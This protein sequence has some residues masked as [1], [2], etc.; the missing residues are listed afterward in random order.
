MTP[1][2]INFCKVA[3]LITLVAAFA[4]TAACSRAVPADTAPPFAGDA[5]SSAEAPPAAPDETPY[6]DGEKYELAE[7]LYADVEIFGAVP[8]EVATF[9]T[10]PKVFTPDVVEE[11]FLSG[12]DSE[13]EL[14]WHKSIPRGPENPDPNG[15]ELNTANG[16]LISQGDGGVIYHSPTNKTD[17]EIS[18]V[19]RRYAENVQNVND[20]E[21]SHMTRREAQEYAGGIIDALGV[22]GEPELRV[23]IGMTAGGIAEYQNTLTRDLQWYAE[24][25]DAGRSIL[26]DMLGEKD[27]A[28]YLSFVFNYGDLPL[29]NYNFE[30]PL[31][32]A[33]T[34]NVTI[35][36]TSCEVLIVGGELRTFNLTG[37]YE[38]AGEER[39][40][41][42]IIG[43]ADVIDACREKYELQIVSEPIIFKKMFL[44]YIATRTPPSTKHDATVT[45]SPY[46]CIELSSEMATETGVVEYAGGAE[47]FNA[48]TGKDF[49][50]AG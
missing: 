45:F 25:I 48:I 35:R 32:T 30:R 14:T 4:A 22:F 23:F 13:R 18:T 31:Y 5:D 2:L 20:V 11:L 43:A 40:A 41:V 27:E 17:D 26:L 16:R 50:Y 33:S 24:D 3:R 1:K 19:M 21:L 47:R 12:D 8:A 49:A 6:A 46:W 15:F 34:A 42:P 39:A 9:V 10:V 36:S 37:S 44:E 7:N 28:Y 38:A 29:F